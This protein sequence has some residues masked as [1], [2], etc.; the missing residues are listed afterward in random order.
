[1]GLASC[2]ETASITFKY[3]SY[4]YSIETKDGKVIKPA[5]W[6]PPHLTPFI[7]YRLENLP[8]LPEEW[9]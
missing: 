3:A 5:G 7:G 4:P 2:S 8:I 9:K 6:V 1:M